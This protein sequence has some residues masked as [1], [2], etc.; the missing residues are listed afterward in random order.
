MTTL[1]NRIIKDFGME[2]KPQALP[3]RERLTDESG[4]ISYFRLV[5]YVEKRLRENH[6]MSKPFQAAF[7][8]A[9]KLVD[10]PQRSV[11]EKLKEIC[12]KIPGEKSPEFQA[13]AEFVER[14]L[15]R[16]V[17]TYLSE[18]LG[19]YELGLIDS[20]QANTGWE[21]LEV[22]SSAFALT[23]ED[24]HRL[25][26]KFTAITMHPNESYLQFW[27]RISG[28]ALIFQGSAF[29]KDINDRIQL[30]VT[31]IPK[32]S[33]DMFE[34]ILA[35][36]QKQNEAEKI[37]AM[38]ICI[39]KLM[40]V[41]RLAEAPE[42]ATRE[43]G[44]IKKVGI[45]PQEKVAT[46]IICH[47]CGEKG[48]KKPN[49]PRE[50]RTKGHRQGRNS[51]GERRSRGSYHG[52]EKGKGRHNNDRSRITCLRCG[53]RGH[54]A[55]DC[56]S[57]WQGES[58]NQLGEDDPPSMSE[59]ESFR[60]EKILAL[61]PTPREFATPNG[62]N[63]PARRFISA[64]RRVLRPIP[65]PASDNPIVEDARARVIRL[66]GEKQSTTEPPA[67]KARCCSVLSECQ[68]DSDLE[69]LNISINSTT[70]TYKK[71]CSWCV[72]G[73]SSVCEHCQD[74]NKINERL[75]MGSKFI[76]CHGCNAKKSLVNSIERCSHVL[77]YGTSRTRSQI[78][79]LV[80]EIKAHSRFIK[81]RN[82]V[83]VASSICPCRA[84]ALGP[85]NINQ[86]QDEIHK[87]DQEESESTCTTFQ[88]DSGSCVH[89]V[90]D[91]RYLNPN[92]VV[93]SKHCFGS[94]NGTMLEATQKG[95]ISLI[96][97][98]GCKC[99]LTAYLIPKAT[100]CLISGMLLDTEGFEQITYKGVLTC[101]KENKTLKFIKSHKNGPFYFNGSI[102]CHLKINGETV[103]Q[104]QRMPQTKQQ[105]HSILGHPTP[106]MLDNMS[107]I[108]PGIYLNAED[109]SDQSCETCAAAF[110]TRASV[111]T[112]RIHAFGFRK[113]EA[114]SAD[115]LLYP[116]GALG[117][118]CAC[119]IVDPATNFVITTLLKHK[120]VFV[121]VKN[122]VTL[123]DSL[124]GVP[125]RF[126]RVD[127]GG[128]FTASKLTT[129]AE[130][131]GISITYA[132]S[133][134]HRG[135]AVAEIHIRILKD[136][137]RALLI[138][139]GMGEKFWPYA[140][141][142]ATRLLNLR[143]SKKSYFQSRYEAFYGKGPP[144]AIH[145]R[146]FG[147]I[148]FYRPNTLANKLTARG[149]RGIYM[150]IDPEYRLMKIMDLDTQVVH[151]VRSVYTPT[152]TIF[153][154]APR[155]HAVEHKQTL[156]GTPGPKRTYIKSGKYS[157]SRVGGG[158][159]INGSETEGLCKDTPKS[160]GPD[161]SQMPMGG[162]SG[163]EG[164]VTRP[165][166]KTIRFTLD[167]QTVREGVAPNYLTMAKQ[168]ENILLVDP[169]N[170]TG[171]YRSIHAALNSEEGDAYKAALVVEYD[172]TVRHEV[173]K[174]TTEKPGDRHLRPLVLPSKKMNE[175][176]E[177]HKYKVRFALDGSRQVEGIHFD[178]AYSPVASIE[179]IRLLLGFA[180]KHNMQAVQIDVKTAYF[181]GKC[182]SRCTFRIPPGFLQ[183]LEWDDCSVQGAGD[184]RVILQRKAQLL[185]QYRR[186]TKAHPNRV[187]GL[188][189]KG[190]P[191]TKD[192]G[193][194]WYE[195]LHDFFLRSGFTRFKS[196]PCIF[197][198]NH[199][200]HGF[201]I[202]CAYVDDI[203]LFGKH[204]EWV[205]HLLRKEFEI[206][207]GELTWY[208]GIQFKWNPEKTAVTLV[209]K[210]F[211]DTIL[212][213]FK[214]ENISPGPLPIKKD[215]QLSQHDCPP[216]GKPTSFPLAR[217]VGQ[218]LYLARM[219]R[220]DL[221]LAVQI[222]S[223]FVSN[224]GH[225]HSLAAKTL[226]GYIAGTRDYG[227]T[228]DSTRAVSELT[229]FADAEFANIDIDTRKSYGSYCV[230]YA[231]GPIAWNV[232]RHPRPA[233]ST[234][235]AEYYT[236]SRCGEK[237][238][239]LRQLH[240]EITN[241]HPM[242]THTKLR[243]TPIYEDNQ[244]A[245]NIAVGT[246]KQKHT[247]HV[248]VRYHIIQDYINQKDITVVKFRGKLMMVDAINKVLGRREF[249]EKVKYLLGT[250]D[251]SELIAKNMVP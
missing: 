120:D 49:C 51:R 70:S 71:N 224:P 135:N 1:A 251:I 191:G 35:A 42:N 128:E 208:L 95:K 183:Y 93:P 152:E 233:G 204:T 18:I 125:T 28:E 218:A 100:G 146:T 121:S 246:C 232:A 202:A 8:P 211:V 4:T 3:N 91:R 162:E 99:V 85:R 57:P 61:T 66:L 81:L 250:C 72:I 45:S 112:K 36:A 48:H 44:E 219:S 201:V 240:T 74:C 113:G 50:E 97:E 160:Q 65:A 75:P 109:G 178:E 212:K 181:Y 175:H 227:I 105:W 79:K 157:K 220:P 184:K 58:I 41:Q 68:S 153:P 222:L 107:A 101:T 53:G 43:L 11:V 24:L 144:T 80:K 210:A 20:M 131:R 170:N 236:L 193:K 136:M 17:E 32:Q 231:G 182:H 115:L 248:E 173:F 242:L 200:Q 166:K 83:R 76:P 119:V 90:N 186:L 142:Y 86:V 34:Q 226:L 140:L 92:S 195:T 124:H 87:L 118:T 88:H 114:L 198:Q 239:W 67:K 111:R 16:Q 56:P 158:T 33:N 137:V 205:L 190:I 169:K 73:D 52:R 82:H 5:R 244:T 132:P 13:Y 197:V 127:L 177:L 167:G 179:G 216:E 154:T 84:C 141:L 117:Y 54:I 243:P 185:Q 199:P 64:S 147:Q 194:L 237:V 133:G 98:D 96:G 241:A 196:D 156:S 94:A 161:L 30:F 77:R 39:S 62:R 171:S 235:V 7:G 106:E 26:G 63:H 10:D 214:C 249:D 174:F 225:R 247:K 6:N 217:F 110:L 148:V 60:D 207:A 25:S 134:D 27:G 209:Q 89:V 23:A 189:L 9:Y 176:G 40:A 187:V 104:V 103:A 215:L 122:A 188:A 228:L 139:A 149:K 130:A 47:G 245:L 46:D 22:I 14:H 165:P 221:M 180:L 229:A 159:K 38:H 126:L 168:S 155:N 31:A 19:D 116:T 29:E 129:W 123:C 163:S 102:K 150:G 55:K 206:V 15:V 192:A 78:R 203:L 213:N 223:R 69:P 230:Y 138:H 172:S 2:I 143:P 151:E 108:V 21:Q 59:D 12:H 37:K 234:S 164:M 238:M 145:L